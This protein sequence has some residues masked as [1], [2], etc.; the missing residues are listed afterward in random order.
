MNETNLGDE[1]PF[2]MLRTFLC[3]DVYLKQLELL[4]SGFNQK[5]ERRLL[6]SLKINMSLE[7]V[8]F[9]QPWRV[10]NYTAATDDMDN[11]FSDKFWT[12]MQQYFVPTLR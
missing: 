6:K 7:A 5:H 3:N 1:E 12:F 9:G 11:K 4:K 8:N 10:K 2:K